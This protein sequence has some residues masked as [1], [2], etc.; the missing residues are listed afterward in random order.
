MRLG[1]A[2]GIV[3]AAARLSLNSTREKNAID[4]I[5]VLQHKFRLT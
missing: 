5:K 1:I 4:K 3:K 2:V